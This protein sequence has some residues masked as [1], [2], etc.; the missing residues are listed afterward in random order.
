MQ[1][2]KTITELRPFTKQ[3]AAGFAALYAAPAVNHGQ[4]VQEPAETDLQLLHRIGSLCSVHLGI[5][6]DGKLIGDCALHHWIPSSAELEIGGAL[7]PEF[8]GLGIMSKAF[9]HLIAIAREMGAMRIIGR[10]HPQNDAAIRLVERLGFVKTGIENG[11]MVL[12]HDIGRDRI[13]ELR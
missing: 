11:E 9:V 2:G 13:H 4:A 10:T 6:V 12:R 7:L 3:D 8:Q 5:F 1:Q